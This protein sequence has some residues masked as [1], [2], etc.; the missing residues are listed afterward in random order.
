MDWFLSQIQPAIFISYD[1]IC[2]VIPTSHNTNNLVALIILHI[3]D[4]WICSNMYYS[5]NP[6]PLNSAPPSNRS[7]QCYVIDSFFESQS[8]CILNWELLCLMFI[9]KY[10]NADSTV[11]IL[12]NY[13]YY[14]S[15]PVGKCLENWRF[16]TFV[17]NVLYA[18]AELVMECQSTQAGRFDDDPIQY[19]HYHR[20]YRLRRILMLF[21][22]SG[23]SY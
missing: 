11:N 1:W 23:S 3:F 15:L 17:V 19:Y 20:E 13:S 10:Y 21:H 2:I 16:L 14:Y 5:L 12:T 18:I 22:C 6:R 4:C 7:H 9:E 8:F